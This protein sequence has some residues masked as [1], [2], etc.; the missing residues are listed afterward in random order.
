[1]DDLI[2]TTT[3][4]NAAAAIRGAVGAMADTQA[5]MITMLLQQGTITSLT[6]QQMINELHRTK[7][8]N[9]PLNDAESVRRHVVK[10]IADHLQERVEWDQA[11]DQ[12]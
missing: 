3:Q 1:M 12:Q 9:P 5:K 10:W 7:Y 8:N 6:A 11:T 4:R 2:D